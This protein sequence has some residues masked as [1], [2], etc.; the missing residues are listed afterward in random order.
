MKKITLLLLLTSFVS[1]G[2]WNQLGSDIDGQ[3]ANE[4][5]GS[6]TKLNSD[7]TI[8]AISIPRGM[9]N[10]IMKGKVRVFQWNGTSWL[11]KG[12]DIIGTNQGDVF[13]D[14][15]SISSDGNTIAIGAPSFLNPN[16]LS[17]TGPTG[18]TRIFEWNGSDW[19]QKGTDILGE[20]NNDTSGTAV[21]LSANG[22]IVA[23]G[24]GSNDGIN[25]NASG[26]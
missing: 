2:Q 19:V 4:Q 8:V 17:P 16:Y 13:G 10:G 12:P 3:T 14:S 1:F 22:T 11:Q 6:S 26:H 18:Y 15:I 9:D 24:A 25:G 7:G 20:S 23:I 5:S 21:S